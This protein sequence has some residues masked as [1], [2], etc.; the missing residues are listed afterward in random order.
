MRAIKHSHAK[1]CLL[2]CYD[3]QGATDAKKGNSKLREIT[4]CTNGTNRSNGRAG[5]KA[6]RFYCK[7]SASGISGIRYIRV[8]RDWGSSW[9]PW[10]AWV[11]DANGRVMN[12]EL[13][14]RRGKRIL[15]QRSEEYGD[16]SEQSERGSCCKLTADRFL[17]R[18]DR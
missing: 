8:I 12:A 5:G 2:P 9:R 11:S 4:N 17:L 10:R 16:G 6:C 18:A 14:T 13:G 1:A 15:T 3:R 7:Q